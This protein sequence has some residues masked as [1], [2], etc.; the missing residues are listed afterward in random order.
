MRYL[1]Q[2]HTQKPLRYSSHNHISKNPHF[3]FH[4]RTSNTENSLLDCDIKVPNDRQAYRFHTYSNHP[5]LKSPINKITQPKTP[6]GHTLT[7]HL[8]LE[9]MILI[10]DPTVSTRSHLYCQNYKGLT[11]GSHLSRATLARLCLGP[12]WT[13]TQNREILHDNPDHCSKD[14]LISPFYATIPSQPYNTSNQPWSPSM[15]LPHPNHHNRTPPQP[16]LASN[17]IQ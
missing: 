7:T 8:I 2:D 3:A 6:M 17:Y 11:Y 4:P 9:L 16:K 1:T 14:T 10:L 5:V 15:A 12:Q 13:S